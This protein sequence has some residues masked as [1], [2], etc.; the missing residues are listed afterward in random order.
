M[1]NNK[2]YGFQPKYKDTIE[3]TAKLDKL[4]PY[5]FRKGMD[6]EL[7]A[8]GCSRL[9]ESTIEERE[10]AT[11]SVL[12]NLEEHGG[13]YTCLITYET[14]YRNTD[15][16]PSF[17]QWLAEQE[18]NNMKEVGKEGK[19]D[20][21]GDIKPNNLNTIKMK[22]IQPLKEAITK[23]I[24][25][26]LS[27]TSADDAKKI[28]KDDAKKAASDKKDLK[29]HLKGKKGIDKQIQK[30][31]DERKQ[32]EEKRSEF[33]SVYKNSKKD[34]KATQ[35]YKDKVLPLQDRIKEIDK[36]IKE[37]ET[38]LI[39]LAKEEKMMRREAAGMMMD[40]R[41][42]LEILEIIKEAGVDLREGAGGVKMYYEIAKT[43]Y[44]EGLTAGLNK[45]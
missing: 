26:I 8:L 6:Y 9:A 1:A 45:E 33:F 32:K 15:T 36:E 43:A 10:K 22:T 23:E 28:N 42:H 17:K 20:K 19:N 34:T 21:M 24:K 13:Y 29:K 39:G 37:L 27:E 41:I 31:E 44:M 40:K 12:K 4:N 3:S 35:K 25:N 14:K 16:K 30:L 18:E 5:E 2:F 7:T 38:Q 11:E